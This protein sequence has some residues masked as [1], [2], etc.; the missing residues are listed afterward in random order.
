MNAREIRFLILNI[1][2][3]IA[4][5]IETDIYLPAFPDM[6]TYF[7]ASEEQIQQLLTWNFIGMCFAGPF[8]GPLSDAFGRR[9]P[10][11]TALA[12]F[13]A[14]SMITLMGDRFD[15]MLVGRILQ[16]IGSGGCFTLGTAFIFDAFREERAVVA[17]NYLNTIFPCIMAGAP[18]LG[19][20]LNQLY[21]FRANFIAI[22][23]LVFM[24]LAATWFFLPETLPQEKR[25]P[26]EWRKIASDFKTACTSVPFWLL[27]L[28]VCFLFSIW[29]AFLSNISVLY[30][31]ELGVSKTLFPV[32]QSIPLLAWLVASLSSNR[33]IKQ[34]GP[35]HVKR[36]GTLLWISGSVMFIIGAL[37]A[38]RNPYMHIA[39]M[40]L[41]AFGINWFQGLYFPEAMQLHP[42]IK[43]I[44]ASLLTSARVLIAAMVVGITSAFYNATIYPVAVA[45]LVVLVTVV[46]MMLIYENRKSSVETSYRSET[47]L[48]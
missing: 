7:H 26:L 27:V 40:S 33:V 43:G 48:H 25:R 39:S 34:R 47:L 30:V 46:P 11:L 5:G 24:S 8:Y 36:I 31:L 16:G 22:A 6:M 38:P 18:A 23:L 21:G 15:I 41:Y 12:L 19:G 9:K 44:T 3:F 2:I 4:A 10:L 37:L 14:G 28:S 13:F 1:I 45:M 17:L 32:L 29:M 35:A 42:E 20:L